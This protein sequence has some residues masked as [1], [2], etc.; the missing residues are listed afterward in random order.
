MGCSASFYEVSSVFGRSRKVL[1]IF[2]Y[3]MT[4]MT[5]PG[6]TSMAAFDLQSPFRQ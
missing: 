1:V 2:R 4:S 6:P 5:I 3:S